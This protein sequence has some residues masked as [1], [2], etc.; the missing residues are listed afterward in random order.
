MNKLR[1][2]VVGCGG[3]TGHYL[4]VYRSLDWVD[5]V[6]CI[7]T[8]LGRAESAAR[9]LS[10]SASDNFNRSLEAGVDAIIINTPNH[11]HRSQAVAALEA[12]KHVLLQKPVAANL[13]DAAAIADAAER[14]E[15]RG[16]VSGLYMSYFDQPLIH[17]FKDMIDSGW[18]GNVAH[19][20]ARLMHRG[21]MILSDEIL[22][23]R[24]NW[25]GKTGETGGGCFIQLAVHFIHLFE[26][27]SAESFVRV[28]AITKNLHCPGIEG[29]DIACAILELSNGA[30]VTLDMAWCTAGEQFSIHGTRGS[31]QY[32]GNRTL[33]LESDAGAFSGRVLDYSS[34]QSVYEVLAPELGDVEN[35]YNQQRLFL[36]AA[37]DRRP[38]HV[39]IRKGV[40]DLQVVA[41][42]YEAA[43][44]GRAVVLEPEL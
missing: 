10:S 22:D 17:D 38:A 2:A 34:N 14:A 29:E 8:D 36:E 7:D 6:V 28:T 12:G 23:G 9:L 42:V 3:I 16:Q 20:Y 43:R 13:E 44:S 15:K 32:I 33:M 21:G 4:N 27:L 25:R 41:A 1:I 26:W 37:R 24:P 31:A 35:P 40:G 19:F 30:L 11:L 18:F 5:V 39:P